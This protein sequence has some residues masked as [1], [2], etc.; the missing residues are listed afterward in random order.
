MNGPA[1]LARP[2]GRSTRRG[3]QYLLLFV[4]LMVG[5][6]GLAGLLDALLAQGTD[7]AASDE[8]LARSI[9]FTVIGV[10]LLAA[11]ALWTRRTLTGR[12]D[13]QRSPAW[14]LF[15]TVSGLVSLLI[16]LV[17]L[18]AVLS[19]VVGLQD[20]D[21]TATANA[22]VWTG[23]WAVLWWLIRRQPAVGMTEPYLLLGSLIGLVTGVAGF[24]I[25]LSGALAAWTGLVADAI[26]LGDGD[27]HLA[28]ALTVLLATPVWFLHWCRG[29]DRR[30][31]SPIHLAYVLLVGVAGSLVVT[32]AA[33]S[34]AVHRVA[35]WLVGTPW[36]DEAARY[37]A[38]LPGIVATTVAGALSLAY[39]RAV[40][41]RRTTTT[42]TD[43][44]R[45]RDYLLATV[46]LGATATGTTI[47]VVALVEAIARPAVIAGDAALNTL[48]AAA[49]L[50]AAGTPVWLHHWRRGQRWAL[51]DPLERHSRVRRVQQFAVIGVATLV[52]VGS[53]I[54][55]VWVLVDE[56]LRGAS[57]SAT[58]H[59][60]RYPLGLLVSAGMVAGYHWTVYVRERDDR[61]AETGTTHSFVLLV[62]V[63]DDRTRG[64]VA[65]ATGAQVWAWERT[66][67]ARQ[68]STA[69]VLDALRATTAAEV[70]VTAGDGADGARLRVVPVE[71]HR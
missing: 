35:V 36:T 61:A 41:A 63:G 30:P 6:L 34:V 47:V 29:A 37:F 28:A 67:R 49:T 9:A 1:P 15:L 56:I 23:A 26:V 59:A 16:A 70:M 31:G 38:G 51:Q 21:P 24:A 52:A 65:R 10:P 40:L 50:L 55:G 54:A 14:L 4:L 19:S 45:V 57:G 7:L 2:A 33:G 69:D 68:G 32:V 44:D 58:L 64:E 71:R 13:E 12:P 20:F 48:L 17:A 22:V 46:G 3:F 5:G 18:H 62:G 8:S 11:V 25:L 60:L 53:L 42:R 27:R 39:H 43:V 66:D